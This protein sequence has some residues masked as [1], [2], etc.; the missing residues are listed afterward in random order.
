VR[1]TYE[2][3][4]NH[5]HG[6]QN[7]IWPYIVGDKGYPMLPWLMIPPSQTDNIMK[8]NK[9]RAKIIKQYVHATSM[10]FKM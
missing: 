7:N 5:E 4:F 9:I 6:S 10:G 1:A 2:G 3:F 8:F